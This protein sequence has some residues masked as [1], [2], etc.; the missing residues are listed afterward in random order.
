MSCRSRITWVLAHI[1]RHLGVGRI[2]YA[3]QYFPIWFGDMPT[4]STKD[5][6]DPECQLLPPSRRSLQTQT[7]TDTIVFRSIR[8]HLRAFMAHDIFPKEFLRNA[9]SLRHLGFGPSYNGGFSTSTTTPKSF[10]GQCS[11]TE[12][13]G[14]TT[15]LNT[16]YHTNLPVHLDFRFL[17]LTAIS[18]SNSSGVA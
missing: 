16:L 13:P 7:D 9:S 2:D 15:C 5:N 10:P 18:T 11:A 17:S 14:R 8:Q 3:R 6:L 12:I 4:Q 1:S